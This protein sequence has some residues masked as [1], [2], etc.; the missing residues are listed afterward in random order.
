MAKIQVRIQTFNQALRYHGGT[1]L[2]RLIHGIQQFP[3]PEL[4]ARKLP[5]KSLGDALKDVLDAVIKGMDHGRQSRELNVIGRARLALAEKR[6]I[7]VEQ[8]AKLMPF[9]GDFLSYSIPHAATPL[10]P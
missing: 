1:D 2:S 6:V 9:E 4:A 5:I 8:P 10:P 3:V 7:R